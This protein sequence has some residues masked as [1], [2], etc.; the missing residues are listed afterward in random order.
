MATVEQIRLLYRG[1][2]EEGFC[3][4]VECPAEVIT[5]LHKKTGM[6]FEN[7][8]IKGLQIIRGPHCTSQAYRNK[9]DQH[10]LQNWETEDYIVFENIYFGSYSSAIRNTMM[11]NVPFPV[12]ICDKTKGHTRFFKAGSFLIV[13]SIK[14]D[15]LTVNANGNTIRGYL[16]LQKYTP[17]LPKWEQKKL[18]QESKT[19]SAELTHDLREPSRSQAPR[20]QAPRSQAPWSQAPRS[21]APPVATQLRQPPLPS[22]APV[23]REEVPMVIQEELFFSRPTEVC[24]TTYKSLLEARFAT[25]LKQ[26]GLEFTYE[27]SMFSL[28]AYDRVPGHSHTY[29]PD[30]YIKSLRLHI[31]LK[32]HFPHLE[33]LDLCEQLAQLGYDVVL[34]YGTEFVP[35]F[36]TYDNTPGHTKRHYNHQNALRGLAWSGHTGTRMAG[37]AVFVDNES[38][39]TIEC[40]TSV[41]SLSLNKVQSPRLLAAFEAARTLH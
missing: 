37:E 40:V 32:P 27:K 25:F 8:L 24:G 28:E 36:Q 22:P 14:P 16:L 29:H 23:Q 20:S 9:T 4:D 26:L 33:E 13:Q 6:D 7:T 1:V 5:K 19:L 2:P 15:V 39:V 12:Y 21:Q 3:R 41:R 11:Q 34:F 30:F 17:P 35:S 18:V 10:L 31:E 38:F